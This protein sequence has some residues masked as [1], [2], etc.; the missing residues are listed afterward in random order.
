MLKKI[1]RY[2]YEKEIEENKIKKLQ[3]DLIDGSIHLGSPFTDPKNI[4]N[5][6]FIYQMNQ[7][8][9]KNY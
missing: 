7:K 4:F 2:F 8:Y 3:K 6:S 1:Q 5:D 9:L